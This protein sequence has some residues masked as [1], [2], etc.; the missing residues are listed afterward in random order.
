MFVE[1]ESLNKLC[2]MEEIF[3]KRHSHKIQ[4]Y[5]M[6]GHVNFCIMDFLEQIFL[7]KSKSFLLT[8]EIKSNPYSASVDL[9]GSRTMIFK[10]GMKVE[11]GW[12]TDYI[13]NIFM[14]TISH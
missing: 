10:D 7:L 9:I 2:F 13:F 5:R 4:L 14:G 12:L 1:T 8:F 6:E 11:Y 3:Y